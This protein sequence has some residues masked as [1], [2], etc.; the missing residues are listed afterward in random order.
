MKKKLIA[1]AVVS[2]LAGPALAGMSFND[3]DTDKNGT[4]SKAEFDAMQMKKKEWKE[5]HKGDHMSKGGHMDNRSGNTSGSG[6]SGTM[7]GSSSGSMDSSSSGT[8]N[9]NATGGS[10]TATDDSMSVGT[11]GGSDSSSTGAS[12]TGSSSTP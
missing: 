10:S 9:D 11:A 7:S 4:I 1:V 2:L 5:H 3:I 8:I 6:G 12:S